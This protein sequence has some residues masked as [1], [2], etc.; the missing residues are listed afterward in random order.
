MDAIM[1][2]AMEIDFAQDTGINMYNFG[3]DM[4]QQSVG[5]CSSSQPLIRGPDYS[6]SRGRLVE[7]VLVREASRDS[8]R[9]E[10][11]DTGLLRRTP[12][13]PRRRRFAHPGQRFGNY[14]SNSYLPDHQ[15]RGRS[16]RS[17]L[18]HYSPPRSSF[19]PSHNYVPQSLPAELQLA[20]AMAD[21][22]VKTEDR[23][24]R[25]DRGGNGGGRGRGGNNNRKRRYD[26]K[27]R[28]SL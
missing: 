22:D 28:D 5:E 17:R 27:I 8:R 12:T 18:D 7:A 3:P 13:S 1:D 4:I 6:W 24:D 9:V 14:D 15:R 2:G 19:R 16:P 25:R 10:H 11:L 26:G 20:R 23:E 21:L